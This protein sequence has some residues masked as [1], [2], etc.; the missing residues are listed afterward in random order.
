MLWVADAAT[1]DAMVVLTAGRGCPVAWLCRQAGACRGDQ[2]VGHVCGEYMPAAVLGE[3]ARQISG[4][5]D[6]EPSA[7]LRTIEYQGEGN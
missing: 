7:I 3:R 4:M 2:W 5:L 6:A 1:G